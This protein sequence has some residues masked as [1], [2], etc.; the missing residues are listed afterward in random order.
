MMDVAVPANMHIGLHQD[1]IARKGWSVSV[2]EALLA[3]GR[4]DT[5]FVDLRER[6]EREK[7]GAISGSLHAPY[8]ALQ[9]NIAQG[10]ILHELAE[11]TGKTILFYC[12]YGERSA[13]AVEAAQQAGIPTARHIAGG[14]DAWRKAGGAVV[15]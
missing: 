13:M 1:E 4:R 7:H 10:G 6:S 3:L 15:R 9:E 2:G 8:A 5:A 11:A 14:L 12:A